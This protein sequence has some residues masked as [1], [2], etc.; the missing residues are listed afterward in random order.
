[1]AFINF[2]ADEQQKKSAQNEVPSTY[3][4]TLR[5]FAGTTKSTA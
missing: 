2:N 1:V 3:G 5:G 4:K